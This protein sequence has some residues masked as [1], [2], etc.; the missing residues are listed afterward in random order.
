MAR[1]SAN[2]VGPTPPHSN[3]FNTRFDIVWTRMANIIRPISS[4]HRKGVHLNPYLLGVQL[5]FQFAWGTY[6]FFHSPHDVMLSFLNM[7]LIII[8]IASRLVPDD[9]ELLFRRAYLATWT[10]PAFIVALSSLAGLSEI[11]NLALVRVGATATTPPI[12]GS[13]A[14]YAATLHNYVISQLILPVFRVIN[15]VFRLLGM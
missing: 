1:V 8:T 15:R 9:D 13:S 5:I 6:C 2:G 3:A 7:A 10:I 12:E 11:D 4:H 14:E